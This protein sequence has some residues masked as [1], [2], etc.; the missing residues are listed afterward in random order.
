MC[1]RFL[2]NFSLEACIRRIDPGN[3]NKLITLAKCFHRK[4]QNTK[5]LSDLRMP[6]LNSSH[7]PAVY[8]KLSEHQRVKP[9]ESVHD[10]GS[11]IEW[12]AR[13][14]P[15]KMKWKVK[16]DD[17]VEKIV[18]NVGK[19]Q[20]QCFTFVETLAF[21]SIVLAEARANGFSEVAQRLASP[22]CSIQLFEGQSGFIATKHIF[23]FSIIWMN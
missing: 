20:F 8:V 4:K 18:W 14:L 9:W 2:F 17:F 3:F 6:L 22:Q 23:L 15:Q 21:A 16:K 5:G 12:A 1:R 19:F 7:Q 13:K 11:L 10:S